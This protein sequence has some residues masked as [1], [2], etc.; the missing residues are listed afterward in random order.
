MRSISFDNGDELPMLGL[1]TWKSA[2]NEAYEAVKTALEVG[3][4]HVDCAPIYGNE[5]EVGD[6]LNES[7]EEG[8]VDRDDVWLTSKLWNDAHAADEV[9]PAL[10]RTLDD[11][12]LDVLDLYLIHWPVALEPGVD[13]PKS[14]SDFRSLEEVP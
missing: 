3:Y 8:L 12:Q 5:A 9:R 13:F 1:G 14:P 11:L 7:F 4:R 10:E 6:A 2:P